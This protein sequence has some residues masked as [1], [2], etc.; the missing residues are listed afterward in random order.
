MAEEA[1]LFIMSIKEVETVG[2]ELCQ[3][4]LSD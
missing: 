3:S 2:G 1:R 4:E